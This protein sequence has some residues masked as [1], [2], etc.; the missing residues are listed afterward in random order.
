MGNARKFTVHLKRSQIELLLNCLNFV[1]SRSQFNENP[2]RLRRLQLTE[3]RLQGAIDY[4]TRTKAEE[5]M[6]FTEDLG[7][8]K[9]CARCKD[10]W[11]ATNEYFH[12]RGDGLHSYCKACVTERTRELNAGAPRK[13]E[14]RSKYA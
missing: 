9:K 10:F 4:P 3:R 1:R 5:K 11:P 6:R 12:K 7:W 2:R 8:E 13:H 14:R